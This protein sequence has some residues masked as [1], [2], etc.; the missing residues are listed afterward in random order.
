MSLQQPKIPGPKA[1]SQDTLDAYLPDAF[2]DDEA[3][4]WTHRVE[5]LKKYKNQWIGIHKGKVLAHG[6]DLYQVTQKAFERSGSCV[7]ITKV[8][9]EDRISV[10]V[11]RVEFDYAE[12]YSPFP[13]P[14]AEV[15]FSNIHEEQSLAYPDVIPD[16]GA[17]IT[18][19]PLEDC[20]RLDLFK[21]PGI[22]LLS[23]RYGPPS[24]ASVLI[25]GYAEIGNTK[26]LC[27]I[28]PVIERERILGRDVLN[29]LT[30]IFRG[31]DH[32]TVFLNGRKSRK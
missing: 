31:K 17:D 4:Y 6:T 11:R 23:H 27:Y 5:L 8:G 9:E 26:Y 30:V 14:Q 16:T 24:R 10:R 29:R 20:Q 1:S 21:T 12:D 15:R 7:Y 25:P 19:L 13:L 18:C 22:R 32:K 2:R 3:F 28:E